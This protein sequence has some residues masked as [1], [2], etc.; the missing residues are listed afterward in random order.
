[1]V[2]TGRNGAQRVL[3]DWKGAWTY[4]KKEVGIPC[5]CDP[6]PRTMCCGALE[7]EKEM[8]SLAMQWCIQKTE[9]CK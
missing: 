5:E 3:F 4:W 1:M 6:E 9:L 2:I 7:W 8:V